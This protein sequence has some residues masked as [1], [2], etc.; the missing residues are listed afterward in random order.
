MEKANSLHSDT[1]LD[2]EREITM[3]K[4]ELSAILATVGGI[5]TTLLGGWDRAIQVLA[6]FMVIDY[7]TGCAVAFKTKTISSATGFMGI[8]KKA[9][10]FLVIIIAAQL[11]N[12]MNAGGFIRTSTILFFMSNEGISILENA[13]EIGI[14][15]PK[16]LNNT[17]VKLRDKHSTEMDE[18]ETVHEQN[19]VDESEGK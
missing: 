12:V 6:L 10:M 18:N 13:S 8:I 4:F 15:F 2:F 9:T 14:R 7:L 1:N 16:L 3:S 19:N 5:T 17:L 11:D